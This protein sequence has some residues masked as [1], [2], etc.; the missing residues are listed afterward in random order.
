MRV[1]TQTLFIDT[2]YCV[3]STSDFTVTFDT[4]ALQ[5]DPSQYMEIVLERYSTMADWPYS[6]GGRFTVKSTGSPVTV[7]LPRGSPTFQE[8]AA[9][10]DATS[11]SVNVRC[12]YDD[13]TGRLVFTGAV[14]ALE[15]AENDA[16]AALLGF[17]GQSHWAVGILTSENPLHAFGIKYI[18]LKMTG[19]TSNNIATTA[20]GVCATDIVGI[21]PV[22]VRPYDWLIWHNDDDA[23]S[24]VISDTRITQLHFRMEDIDGNLLTQ[25]PRQSLQLRIDTYA[26]LGTT[27]VMLSNILRTLELMAMSR[28]SL[29]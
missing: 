20:D 24:A 10:I 2:D 16:T 11:S 25:L 15:F 29:S 23:Y 27:E 4:D 8:L 5:C 19:V 26:K 9:A 21:I 17:S 3:G 22:D 13:M 14:V 7:T 6:V 12:R 1:K 18:C 28:N